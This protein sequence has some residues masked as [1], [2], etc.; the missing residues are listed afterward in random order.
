METLGSMTSPRSL[1]ADALSGHYWTSRNSEI[2]EPRGCCWT[3]PGAHPPNLI[4]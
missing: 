3:A 4:E 1:G 2:F